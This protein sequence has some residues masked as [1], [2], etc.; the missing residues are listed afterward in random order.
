MIDTP[1]KELANFVDLVRRLR[2]A[3]RGFFASPQGSGERKNFYYESKTLERL[4]DDYIARAV[5]EAE[6]SGTLL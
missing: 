2:V 1:E 4:T 5:G 6:K 3:Q